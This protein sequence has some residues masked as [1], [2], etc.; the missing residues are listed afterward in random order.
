MT[1]GRLGRDGSAELRMRNASSC[2]K[3]EW[4][5]TSYEN[6]VQQRRARNVAKPIPSRKLQKVKWCDLFAQSIG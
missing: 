2:I 4:R 3:F 1:K 6:K 5:S